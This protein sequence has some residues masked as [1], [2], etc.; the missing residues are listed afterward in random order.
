MGFAERLH[1][2]RAG[3]YVLASADEGKPVALMEAMACSLPVVAT[4]V[5]DVPDMIR[6]GVS[7]FIIDIGDENALVDRLTR[8]LFDRELM[9]NM[10][11]E[12]KI[13]SEN[14]DLKKQ[15]DILCE[16]ISTC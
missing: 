8:L 4:R 14:F 13:D 9:F 2:N 6:D 3:I 7:G 16:V 11:Q 10:G 12:A 5:G 15:V 1:Y